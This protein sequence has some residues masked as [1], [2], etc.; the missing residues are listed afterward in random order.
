MTIT[1]NGK[2][3]M[4][5]DETAGRSDSSPAGDRVGCGPG[6][7]APKHE[8]SDG[9]KSAGWTLSFGLPGNRNSVARPLKRNGRGEPHFV[10]EVL[11]VRGYATNK[12]LRLTDPLW[13]LKNDNNR[14]LPRT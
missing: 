6:R 5:F 8:T 3:A 10:E 14:G 9:G 1:R 13:P 2:P 11:F 12:T 7:V 4:P